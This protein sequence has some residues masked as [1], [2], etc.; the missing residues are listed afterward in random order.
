MG[1]DNDACDK[2]AIRGED[3]QEEGGA[4]S[5]GDEGASERE[6]RVSDSGRLVAVGY[7]EGD[8]VEAYACKAGGEDGNAD[9]DEDS[10][11]DVDRVAEG[12]ACA[13]D[14]VGVMAGVDTEES[15]EDVADECVE[16]EEVEVA[17]ERDEEGGAD[18]EVRGVRR[19][20]CPTSALSVGLSAARRL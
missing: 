19:G 15:E 17:V 6:A 18:E 8:L 3:G 14:D 16:G 20:W 11:G 9:S 2:R 7:D 12:G 4:E 5:A 10:V 13:D 1:G